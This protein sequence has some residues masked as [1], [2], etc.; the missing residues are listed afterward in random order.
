MGL[1][2]LARDVALDR[3]VAIKVLPGA[4]GVDPGLRARFLREARISAGL[5]HPHVV[6]IH[7]V[8]EHADAVFFAM[9]YVD[10]ETLADRVRRAGPL[11]PGEAARV[12]REVA[13]ALA[14]AHG[15]GVVHRDVKPENVMVERGSGR[16]LVS[17]FGIARSERAPSTLT[18]EG[19]ILGSVAFM[20]PEQAAGEPVDG[21][22]D[23][24][25]LGG[26]GFYLLTG[27]PPFQAPT[28]A[29]L[30]VQRLTTAAPPVASVRPDVPPWLAGVID[31]CLARAPEAR[32][33][34]GEAVAEALVPR[35]GATSDADIAPPVRSFVRAAEQTM[36]L[37]WL[38][39][40]FTVFYGLPS[41]RNLAALAFGIAF[42]AI[43]VSADL[44]RRARELIAEGYGAGDVRWAF[45]RERRSHEAELRAVFDAR[46]TEADRRTR[47]RAWAVLG[48][49]L[50]LKGVTLVR[51][52]RPA[53]GTHPG[54]GWIAATVLADLTT[55]LSL[56]IALNASPRAERR[57]F[58][59][60]ARV[61]EGRFG[62]AFFRLAG[63]G[64]PA[65]AHGGAPGA[66]GA[67]P[68]A[69]A[70]P[71]ALPPAVLARFPELPHTL[72][73]IEAAYASL[74]AREADVARAVAAAG[75]SAAGDVTTDDP[76]RAPSALLAHRDALV[77]D[78]RRAL[79]A[80]RAGRT[81]LAAARENIRVQLLRIGAGV[82]EP[83]DLGAEIAAA[84]A[85]LDGGPG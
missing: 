75:I 58:R 15:R 31:R 77:A 37:V 34:S 30:L 60:T 18:G 13:W 66:R 78:M 28:A 54:G 52:L 47:R 61:W 7:A 45:A 41:T 69:L 65:R 36:W 32:F 9:A 43:V 67:A 14:Y 44:L 12:L 1:V 25:A 8:E 56:V 16:A 49:A 19:E 82:G 71:D 64:R 50:V 26:L 74:G 70:S 17:D 2:L 11:P 10:G 33:P 35:S 29:A 80:A 85:L 73:R 81:A 53:P 62:P 23:L 84:R 55:A 76:T 38:I 46:R 20:S 39:V 48:V 72:R 24:Y 6:P 3:P 5:S 63:V 22:S 57:F 42:G 68:D 27:R 21:R 59:L 40:V 83:D 4:L 51:L 79:D